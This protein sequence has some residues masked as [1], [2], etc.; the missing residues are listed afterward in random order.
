MCKFE[1]LAKRC[2]EWQWGNQIGR[3]ATEAEAL[4]MDAK[5]ARVVENYG[6]LNTDQA[7]EA[8]RWCVEGGARWDNKDKIFKGA[9]RRAT[10]PTVETQAD[11]RTLASEISG[12]A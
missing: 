6:L 5:T 2:G 3:L 11:N 12:L 4:H 1:E 7:R 9:V 8:Q 10:T